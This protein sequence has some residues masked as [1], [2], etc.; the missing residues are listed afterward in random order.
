MECV[1]CYATDEVGTP[2]SKCHTGVCETCWYDSC[3][4]F[5]PICDRSELNTP[6]SCR[7]CHN[8]FHVK[9]INT[10]CVCMS[11]VC[12]PCASS[13]H[14]C[15]CLHNPGEVE[16][17][18]GGC[19]VVTRFKGFDANAVHFA[20]LGKLAGGAV[21]AV[22]EGTNI[23]LVCEHNVGDIDCDVFEHNVPLSAHYSVAYTIINTPSPG[24]VEKINDICH[25]LL[26]N[27]QESS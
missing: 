19:A 12:D 11:W 15:R 16:E 27:C 9:D 3:K 21:V 18:E 10:C 17:M 23:F 8:R 2:C 22:K 24:C 26:T 5:C 13:A 20:V 7:Y 25:K 1:V 4:M 6:Q 14:P